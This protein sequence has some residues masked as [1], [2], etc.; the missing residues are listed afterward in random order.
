MAIV[1]LIQHSHATGKVSIKN[2][3]VRKRKTE[4][5]GTNFVTFTEMSLSY[6]FGN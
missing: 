2:A 4:R 1:Y 5:V 3:L 6:R